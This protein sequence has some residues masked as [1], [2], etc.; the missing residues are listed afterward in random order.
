MTVNTKGSNTKQEVGEWTS[1]WGNVALLKAGN[2]RLTLG[3]SQHHST[4]W[5]SLLAQRAA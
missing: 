3:K 2:V 1:S 5:D 4:I